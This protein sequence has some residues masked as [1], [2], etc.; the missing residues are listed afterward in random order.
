MKKEIYN[1]ITGTSESY[2]FVEKL[3]ESS[4][5]IFYLYSTNINHVVIKELKEKFDEDGELEIDK[6][7]FSYER[8]KSLDIYI[9][10]L[11]GYN[12][13]LNLV[14]KEYIEGEDILKY[15]QNET[16]DKDVFMQLFRYA[17]AINAD[18][19]N[20][21]YFPSN[22]VLKDKTVYYINYK[23]YPYQEELNLRNWGIYY[24]IN[25]EGMGKYIETGNE[26]HINIE[27]EK[28]P[29]ITKILKEKRDKIYL[30]YITW[31][32]SINK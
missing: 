21:D 24:W 12:K 25:S 7:I 30:E 3:F 10:K 6:E 20:L 5:G 26:K 31:K 32:H 1:E 22:F 27:G 11:L 18:N 23:T 29:I 16:L 13:E 14:I 9:P 19:L 28:N 15:I 2:A 17:E 4:N 8:L